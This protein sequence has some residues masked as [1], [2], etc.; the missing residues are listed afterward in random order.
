MM[1]CTSASIRSRLHSGL[2]AAFR[3]PSPSPAH[4]AADY[5]IGICTP[6]FRQQPQFW[7]SVRVSHPIDTIFRAPFGGYYDYTIKIEGVL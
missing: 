1:R 6:H 4:P 2:V 7:I 3:N 5:K